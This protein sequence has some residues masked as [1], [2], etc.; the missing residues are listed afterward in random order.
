MCRRSRSTS[1]PTS[2]TRV[3]SISTRPVGALSAM[4]APWRSNWMMSPSCASSTCSSRL[5]AAHHPLGDAGVLRQL[6]VLAVNR[7]EVA[8]PDQREHQLQLLGAAVSGDVDVLHVGRDDVGAAAGDVAHRAGDRLLVAGNRARREHHGVVGTEL[9]EAVIVDGDAR[10]RRLR[11]ALRAGR[12]AEHVLRGVVRHVG[13]ANLHARRERAGSR[14][15]GR[16]RRSGRCCG[17]RTRPCARTA[18]RGRRAPAS[19]R[20]STRTAATTSLPCVLVNSSSNASMTSISGP[21]KPLRSTLVLSANS[22]S[23]PCEPSSAKR[24]RSKCSPSIGV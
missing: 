1:S 17:R 2:P 9:D 23:T 21:V 10:E 3:T 16:S 22:A 13:V 15:A 12:D 18:P 11:F 7:H 19:G 24:C 5:D 8:R 4:R 20:C 6:A 14:G